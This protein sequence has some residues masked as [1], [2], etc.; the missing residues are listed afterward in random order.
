MGVAA[1]EGADEVSSE[2]YNLSGVR[3]ASPQQG[4]FVNV[5]RMADGSVRTSKLILK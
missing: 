5:S 4:I 2:Y 1:L 3:V